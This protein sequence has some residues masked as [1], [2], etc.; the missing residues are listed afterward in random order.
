LHVEPNKRNETPYMLEGNEQADRSA[1]QAG[2]LSAEHPPL[3]E[4]PFPETVHRFASR[5]GLSIPAYDWGGDGPPLVVAHATGLHARTYAPLV[6]HL[7]P[8]FHCYG[9]DVR[10]QGDSGI[11]DDGDFGWDSIAHDFLAALDGLGLSGRG[12]VY[13]VGHSQGGYAIFESALRRPGT[14][15][16]LFGFE[17]VIFLMRED[18][19]YKLQD[20][21]MVKSALKRRE[22]FGSRHAAYE[23]YRSK[24]PFMLID[25][26][27]LRAYITYGFDDL[28][29]GTIR[30]KCR[31][32]FEAALF[33]NSHTD[34]YNHLGEIT[35][36][37][38]LGLSE[39]TADSFKASVPDQHSQLKDSELLYFEE[40]THM[41]I[42]ERIPEM[43]MI[44]TRQFTS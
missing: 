22:T 18:E 34:T 38:T 40:R 8:H 6:A 26:D 3:Y 19:L 39:N 17:P 2:S 12:D 35:C 1:G 27:A 5:S 44:I 36:P 14:F 15:A 9:I 41:G 21:V 11:P 23:N 20:S 7:R 32:A 29:D 25:D 31:S 16:G 43:A 10:G 33:G 37:V 24:P 4:L 30:L 42:L 28:D 13:G